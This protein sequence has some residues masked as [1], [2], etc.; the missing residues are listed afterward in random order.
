MLAPSCNFLKKTAT[1][2]FPCEICEIFKNT[3]LDRTP[4]VTASIFYKMQF[5]LVLTSLKIFLERTLPLTFPSRFPFLLCKTARIN[6]ISMLGAVHLR[7]VGP[8]R[9]A[10]S[11]RWTDFYPPFIWN[12]LSHFNQKACLSRRRKIVL[13]TIKNN[14]KPWETNY[15]KI[16]V[17]LCRTNVLILFNE[18]LKKKLIKENFILFYRA[19][20]PVRVYMENFHLTLVGSRQNQVRSHLGRLAYFSYEHIFL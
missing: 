19:G 6:S 12:L 9:L 5:R 2:A 4:P 8:A 10:G 15:R 16:L 20:P 3:F 13:I 18:H 1:Q 14:V 17:Q 11:P 7:W